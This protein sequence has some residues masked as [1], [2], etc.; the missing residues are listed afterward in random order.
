MSKTAEVKIPLSA[1]KVGMVV[2][3]PLSWTNHPFLFNRIEIEKNAHI[4]LIKTLNVTFVYLISGEELLPEQTIVEKTIIAPTVEEL[5]K[6]TKNLVRRSIRLGQQRFT[7]GAND[8]RSSFSKLGSDPQGA[9]RSAATLVEELMDHLKETE[10]PYLSF[11][12]AGQDIS[13]NQHGLSVAVIAMMIGQALGLEHTQLRDIAMGALFHDIG[14]QKVPDIIRRKKTHLSDH[15]VNFLNMH[16]KFGYDML[17]KAGLFPAKVLDILL[18]H[19]EWIDGSGYPH[20]LKGKQITIETQVVSLANDFERLLRGG[21]A[22]SP[23]VALGYLFKNRVDKHDP[24]MI[25]TLVKVLGIYP[26]GTLVSLSSGDVAKVMV[27]TSAVKKPIVLSCND[28]GLE[29]EL[30]FLQDESV[31]IVSVIKVEQLSAAAIKA[32]DA[33]SPVSF[34]FSTL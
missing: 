32:L 19:H 16:P 24:A 1:L 26:P 27:T 23:Q 9:Y 33:K 6:E 13:V 28:D 21:E 5:A 31:E 3:L 11:V 20:G 34:Y 4:E 12:N 22:R 2:K 8:C 14:K 10:T 25:A 17:D 18:H 30:R 15:E 7:K 29:P